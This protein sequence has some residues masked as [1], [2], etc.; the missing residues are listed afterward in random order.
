MVILVVAAMAGHGWQRA[1]ELMGKRKKKKTMKQGKTYHQIENE[2]NITALYG[3][4]AWCFA[5]SG[6]GIGDSS[7]R[8]GVG[9]FSETAPLEAAEVMD[10][11]QKKH[12]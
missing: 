10:Y 11:L 5:G 1:E 9:S 4:L 6:E 7:S 12:F 2:L 3:A 8:R